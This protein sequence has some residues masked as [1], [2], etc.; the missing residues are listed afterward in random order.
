MARKKDK[1]Y[2]VYDIESNGKLVMVNDVL[3]RNTAE[4]LVPSESQVFLKGDGFVKKIK[5]RPYK[6]VKKKLDKLANETAYNSAV[7]FS[8]LF[9]GRGN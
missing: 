2:K 1:I 6:E 8:K 9:K 7:E 3:A 5:V 4:I